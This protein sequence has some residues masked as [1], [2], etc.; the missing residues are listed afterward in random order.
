LEITSAS[1]FLM[2]ELDNMICSKYFAVLMEI[3]LS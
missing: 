3:C 1:M 2:G